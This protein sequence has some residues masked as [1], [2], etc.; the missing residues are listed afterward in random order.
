MKWISKLTSVAGLALTKPAVV[1]MVGMILL[2]SGCEKWQL[3]AQVKERCAIDG[4][5]K[6]Y[7]TVKL[8]ANQFFDS[9]LPKFYQLQGVESADRLGKDYQFQ[10]ETTVLKPGSTSLWMSRYVILRRVDNKILG[11][12]VVY[13]RRGGDLPGPWHESYQLCP[14]NI[15]DVDL[16]RKIFLVK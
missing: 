10:S 16:V 9:G 3:D 4:G 1:G 6:V 14:E 11:E 13:G 8:P 15:R 12:L 2:F 7:E 5:I